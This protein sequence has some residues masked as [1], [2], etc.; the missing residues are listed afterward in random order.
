MSSEKRDKWY[1]KTVSE[2]IASFP[3][4][5]PIDAVG[6]WQIIPYGRE[7]FGF[8]E[9][10]LIDFVRRSIRCLLDHEAK[11]VRGAR[12]GKHYWIVQTQYGENADEIVEAI[13]SEWAG[14]GCGDPN[15]G[16]LW[17]ATPKIYE[18]TRK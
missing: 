8:T 17:F 16:G 18:A 1:G 3:A 12:E 2:T 9:G 7:G 13:V 15:L 14:W 11:P 6:L 4:E 5:L 10:E